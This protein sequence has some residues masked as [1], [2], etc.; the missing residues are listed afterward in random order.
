MGSRQRSSSDPWTSPDC[1]EDHPTVTATLDSPWRI[2][3]RAFICRVFIMSEANP[4]VTHGRHLDQL[5][6]GNA[7]ADSPRPRAAVLVETAH[8]SILFLRRIY[9]GDAIGGDLKSRMARSQVRREDDLEAA[10]SRVFPAPDHEPARAGSGQ[11]WHQA[12]EAN[13]GVPR[14]FLPRISD[15]PAAH[16]TFG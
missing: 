13:H 16:A 4:V 12:Q 8:Q 5:A 9:V 1:M 7:H 11:L 14:S 6:G 3:Q 15:T 10:P 2:K